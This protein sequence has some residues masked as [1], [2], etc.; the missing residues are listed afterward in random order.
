MRRI[1]TCTLTVLFVFAVVAP[2]ASAAPAAGH[3]RKVDGTL[4]GPGGF[5]FL[6][7]DGTVTEIGSGAFRA[8]GLTSGTYSFAVC[9]TVDSGITFDGTITLTTAH[10]G[11]LTGTISGSFTG[12]PGPVFDVAVTGGTKRFAHARGALTVGPLVES[13]LSNCNPH[14][15]VCLDWTDTGPITGTITHVGW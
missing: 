2:N 7:C 11:M 5:R 4:T 9:V 10:G 13:D 14:T 3:R 12:G 1:L 6:G 8:R 15:G